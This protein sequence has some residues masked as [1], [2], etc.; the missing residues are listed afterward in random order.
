[1]PRGGTYRSRD[2]F[3]L[4]AD[5]SRFI[6]Y[7]G[8]NS[9]Y[10]DTAV[11]DAINEQGIPVTQND[12]EPVFMAFL[13]PHIRRVIDSFDRKSRTDTFSATCTPAD[14]IHLFDRY[15]LHFLKLGQ[16]D[17]RDLGCTPDRFYA[18]LEHKCRDEIE[19]DFIAAERILKA[20][21]LSHYTYQV[22][23]LQRYFSEHFARSHPE[24]L[25]Q[26]RLDRFFHPIPVPTQPR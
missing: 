22:F 13:D 23:D 3:D 16:V 1:M 11:E 6:I 4:G 19:Y 9:F 5:P 7:P 2:L 25:D 8:G 20:E 12:L 14:A 15:R 21:E 17:H 24:G 26:D 10:I 18:N